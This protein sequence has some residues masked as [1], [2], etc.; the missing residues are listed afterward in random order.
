VQVG[1]DE[2]QRGAVVGRVARA[3]SVAHEAPVLLT[4]ARLAVVVHA[5]GV[6]QQPEPLDRLRCAVEGRHRLREPAQRAG[7]QPAEHHTAPPRLGQR[8]VDAVRA[9]GAEQADD[10]SAADVH[11]VLL[12]QVLARVAGRRGAIASEEREVAGLA[13]EG[14]EGPVEAHHV[15]VGVA[16]G[17]GHEAHARSLDPPDIVW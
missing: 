2:V 3:H 5:V 6:R 4:P 9:P 11:E 14:R 12:E 10:R 13:A 7:A 8:H 15:V 16:R 17:G 1:A